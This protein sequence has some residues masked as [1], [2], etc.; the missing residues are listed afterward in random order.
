L[1]SDFPQLAHHAICGIVLNEAE[2]V[3]SGGKI[4]DGIAEDVALRPAQPSGCL[5]NLRRSRV[6]E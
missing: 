1:S 6:V 4:R 3:R 2:P 5:P